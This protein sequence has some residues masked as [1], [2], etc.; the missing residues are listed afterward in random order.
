ME[1]EELDDFYDEDDAVAFIQNYL[2]QELKEKFSDDDINYIVDLMYEFYEDKG[3]LDE[4][5]EEEINVDID[6]DELAEFIVK[7]A[8]KQK[9]GQFKREEIL[10]I[11]EGELAYCDSVGMF[12]D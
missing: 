12:D 2:P 11:V 8:L 3:W 1:N 4:D 10:L 7:N 6:T 5:S 9:V